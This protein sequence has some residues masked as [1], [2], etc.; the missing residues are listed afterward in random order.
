VQDEEE[1][2]SGGGGDSVTI[3]PGRLDVA[4]IRAGTS[5]GARKA[6][7]AMPPIVEDYSDL[8]G[9]DE[10]DALDLGVSRFKVRWTRPIE[11]KR[12]ANAGRA[13]EEQALHPASPTERHRQLCRSRALDAVQPSQALDSDTIRL[14]S[15]HAKQEWFDHFRQVR[16]A[17]CGRLF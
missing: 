9:D 17:G 13:D 11:S 4:T 15:D 5:G 12:I 8:V 10:A 3:R 2:E 1:V 6:G 14:P 16:R 7:Q